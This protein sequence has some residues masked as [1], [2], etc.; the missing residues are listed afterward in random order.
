MVSAS[1][2]ALPA[3]TYDTPETTPKPTKTSQSKP[4]Q[5]LLQTETPMTMRA[6]V[7]TRRPPPISDTPNETAESQ[8]NQ[9]KKRHIMPPDGG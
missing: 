5:T 7:Q 3:A 9:Q 8:R 2:F 6:T 1:E 4:L